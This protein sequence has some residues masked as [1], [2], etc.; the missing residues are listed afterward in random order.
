MSSDVAT[1]LTQAFE[2]LVA[3]GPWTG[4]DSTASAE[5]PDGRTAWLFSDTMLGSVRPDHSRDRTTPMVHNS[6]VMQDGSDLQLLLGGTPD[7]P[8]ALIDPPGEDFAWIGA[9]SSDGGDLLHVVANT[10]RTTGPEQFDI[11]LTGTVLA[12]VSLG[13]V[14]DV[15]L[16]DLDLGPMVA[17]GSAIV[18]DREH[19]YIY[20]SEFAAGRRYAHV[21]R[22]P[23]GYLDSPWELW[24]GHAWSR[25]PE[26]SARILAHVGTAFGV[27]QV[28]D[29]WLL[30]TF[31][32]REPFL[33]DIVTYSAESPTG[34]W[35]D[36]RHLLT[37]PE[38][39][40]PGIIAYDARVHPHLADLGRLLVSYNV[41]SLDPEVLYADAR[42]YRP[43]FVAPPLPKTGGAS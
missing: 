11:K 40:T 43:R 26:R 23:L 19:T 12:A 10:Y 35:L 16:Q 21:A 33:P 20:G 9:A 8:T 29:G 36:R 41:H 34:P 15:R 4:A 38:M 28:D 2:W 32:C 24:D 25:W 7:K 30:V 22:V 31:D 27:Q 39:A 6:L 14:P 42:V 5:L 37:V 18:D 3:T 13:E 17:W 1:V